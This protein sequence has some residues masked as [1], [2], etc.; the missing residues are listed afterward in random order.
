MSTKW[1]VWTR[2]CSA[3]RAASQQVHGVHHLLCAGRTEE[4][5]QLPNCHRIGQADRRGQRRDQMTDRQCIPIADVFSI[6]IIR[7]NTI[8]IPSSSLNLMTLAD[9]VP[10]LFTV[11]KHNRRSN[12]S[13]VG[14]NP[15]HGIRRDNAGILWLC[16]EDRKTNFSA[17]FF[18]ADPLT[19]SDSFNCA[20]RCGKLRCIVFIR[21]SF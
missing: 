20:P 12:S 1:H 14:T 4:R 2:N 16:H 7:K 21:F 10:L 3:S 15:A 5:R 18:H 13:G 6:E 17:D 8:L 11:S 9:A 19:H